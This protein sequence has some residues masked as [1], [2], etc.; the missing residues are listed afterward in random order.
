M[1]EQAAQVLRI[2]NDKA[3]IE[4]KRQTACGSCSAKAGCGKSLL[5]NVFK[6]K[7]LQLSLDN[8][9]NAMEN[10]NVIVGL[11]ESAILQASFYLY[12]FPLLIMIIA[13]VMAGYLFTNG[14]SEIASITAAVIGLFSGARISR[15][16]LN[17]KDKNDFFKPTLISVVPIMPASSFVVKHS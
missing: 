8:T 3:V 16:I 17:N 13:A 14:L 15:K 6:V 1:I 9:I 10:D 4:V 7:P 12:F 2:D 5:D 11:N